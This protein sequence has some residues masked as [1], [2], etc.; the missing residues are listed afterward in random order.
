MIKTKKGGTLYYVSLLI[1]NPDPSQYTLDFNINETIHINVIDGQN[2]TE[3]S[4]YKE[5]N[6]TNNWNPCLPMP[7]IIIATVS[8][9]FLSNNHSIW[10]DWYPFR[11]C[12]YYN[13]S[14]GGNHM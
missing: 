12:D 11:I 14:R 8:I 10:R 2:K 4:K 6:N 5:L 1:N 7:F 9:T 3:I 13:N